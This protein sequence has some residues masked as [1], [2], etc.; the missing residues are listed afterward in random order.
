MISLHKLAGALTQTV[1]LLVSTDL[2]DA[3]EL[4]AAVAMVQTT[5]P[6]AFFYASLDATRRR[7][8]CEGNQ[9]WSRV[10]EL[11]QEARQVLAAIPG[12][13]VIGPE[14]VTGRPGAGFDPT[15]LVI[16]VQG[17]GLTGFEAKRRLRVDYRVA[18]EMADLVS[19]VCLVTI[20]DSP[21]T[22]AS[23]VRA[24]ADLARSCRGSHHS[25]GEQLATLLRSTGPIVA[26]AP[27]V[28]TPQEAFFSPSE[29]VPL[30]QASGRI[31]AEPV[32]P[33]PPGIPVLAPGELIPPEVIEF[34]QAG[35]AAGMR[36]NGASDPTLTTLRVVRV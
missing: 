8:A 14:L 17:L 15:R 6:A 23:L 12:L 2:V 7:L 35:R 36:F 26:G 1:L 27:Q 9:L 24:S 30:T 13:R 4:R 25:K 29:R 3:A 28:L 19:V 18:V 31:A 5:S 10:L 33:Y 11:A 22:I 34:L 32:T 20:G 21:E 16:D